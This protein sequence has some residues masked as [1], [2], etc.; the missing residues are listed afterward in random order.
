MSQE[1][2]LGIATAW[3]GGCKGVWGWPGNIRSSNWMVK[4]FRAAFQSRI[5]IVHFLLMFFSAR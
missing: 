4:R 3:T 2:F 5:G 1:I